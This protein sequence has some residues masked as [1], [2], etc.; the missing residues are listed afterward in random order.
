MQVRLRFERGVHVHQAD[1][2]NRRVA[3]A[4]AAML[5]PGALAALLFTLWRLAA[6]LGL[7]GEFAISGGLFSHWPVWAGLTAALLFVCMRLN[8]YGRGGRLFP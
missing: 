7:M 1:G 8:S 3:L 5:A 4:A 6:D 2:K